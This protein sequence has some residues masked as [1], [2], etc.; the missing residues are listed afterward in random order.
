MQCK[1]RARAPNAVHVILI[2]PEIRELV[3]EDPHGE[4]VSCSSHRYICNFHRKTVLSETSIDTDKS[5]NAEDLSEDSDEEHLQLPI[6]LC[7]SET[8]GDSNHIPDN[9][10][11]NVEDCT[12]K[13]IET[14]A[15]Y[16]EIEKMLIRN[17]EN[18]EPNHEELGHAE[19]FTSLIKP[20]KPLI[21][22]PDGAIVNLS[23]AISLVNKYCA[24]LPSD[25]FTKLT[26]IWRCCK[27]V[28][29]G[30]T[31]YQ[32]TLRLPINSPMKHDIL[33]LPMPTQTLA[34]RVAALVGCRTLHR[35]REL[36][37]NLQPIG[38]EGFKAYEADWENFELE[39]SDE[40]IVQV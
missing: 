16:M 14:L 25:T 10:Y 8:L 6:K 17:C 7:S 30:F 19:K 26:P 37:D 31:L 36:D 33:G 29:N 23:T 13:M 38:K 22:S 1:G 12:N 32:Y 3:H 20:H 24:K 28:R 39:K 40:K 2:A 18:K 5:E 11:S 4:D 21:N 15:E 9:L 35:S 34:K 27:T